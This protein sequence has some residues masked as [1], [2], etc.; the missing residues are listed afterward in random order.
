[1]ITLSCFSLDANGCDLQ[2]GC[3]LC[4]KF[5]ANFEHNLP[6]CPSSLASI[7]RD[8]QIN[9]QLENCMSICIEQLTMC[10]AFDYDPL[11]STCT[12]I[13]T[14]SNWSNNQNEQS[15]R[16]YSPIQQNHINSFRIVK[17][18]PHQYRNMQLLMNV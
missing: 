11:T 13:R 17:S 15:K 3:Q 8:E 18:F 9:T 1:M 6:L 12:Y 16:Y 10:L 4:F 2:I 7:Q 5:K 14:Y